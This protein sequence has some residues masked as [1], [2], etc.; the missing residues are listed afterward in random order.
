VLAKISDEDFVF[1]DRAE[2][3]PS[4]LNSMMKVNTFRVFF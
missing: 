4:C 2:E 3:D 1:S